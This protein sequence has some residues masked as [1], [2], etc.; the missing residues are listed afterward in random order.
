M[1]GPKGFNLQARIPKGCTVRLLF[2]PAEEGGFGRSLE[3]GYDISQT[4]TGGAL[5]LIWD[6]ALEGV[7]EVY[8]LLS[9]TRQLFS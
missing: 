9:I 7:H 3:L 8:A 1:L 2:Q 4:A 6:G 5:P